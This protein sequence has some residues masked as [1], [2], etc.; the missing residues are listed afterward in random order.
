MVSTYQQS[1]YVAVTTRLPVRNIG[2]VV[3]FQAG[4]K[5][6]SLVHNVQTGPGAHPASH[7][8]GIEGSLDE[9]KAAGE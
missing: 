2:I 6:I 8:V 4:A 3:R 7:S 1:F 9:G 5:K